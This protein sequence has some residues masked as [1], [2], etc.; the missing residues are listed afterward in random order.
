MT[1]QF[2]TEICSLEELG[3]RL[4]II[5]TYQRPYVWGDAQISKLIDD[6]WEA[7]KRNHTEYFIGTILTSITPNNQYELIDGQQRFTT[8]WLIAVAFK[9][10]KK[11]TLLINFLKV[12]NQLRIDFAIRS[13][14]ADYL[15]R[16]EEGKIIDHKTFEEQMVNDDYWLGIAQGVSS[17][18]G[19]LK[20]LAY[21]SAFS[22]S[23]FGDFIFK[24]IKFVKNTAPAN[25][26]LNQLFTTIN[27]SGLQLEQTD[28]LKSSLL[29]KI[30]K[31]KFFYSKVW[32]VCENMQNYFEKNVKEVFSNQNWNTIDPADF[33]TRLFDDLEKSLKEENISSQTSN[34]RYTLSKILNNSVEKDNYKDADL[35][36][37]YTI[38]NDKNKLVYCKSIVSFPQL[39][40]HAYRIYLANRAGESKRDFEQPFHQKNLLLIFKA[41]EKE[42]ETEVKMF[43][44]YLWETRFLLDK[45]VVK[46][47]QNDENDEEELLLTKASYY[48]KKEHGKETRYYTRT[49]RERNN[50]SMLQSVLYF[51]GNYNTQIWLSPYL[52]AMRT[53][54][55]KEVLT[56]LEE[57]DNVLSLNTRLAPE[58]HTRKA[59][60]FLMMTEK[61]K[62]V[63]TTQDRV[64]LLE[65]Y[66]NES[67]G[68]SFKH[69]WFQKL[70][71]IL[72]K[73]WTK[74]GESQ[75]DK[76]NRYRITSK[77]SVEHVFP[78]N[79]EF[80]KEIDKKSLDSFGNLG[81]LSV[82]QN[83]SY[84]HQDVEKKKVDFKNKT[85]YDS[86]KLYYIYNNDVED[87]GKEKIDAH[88]A[89]MIARIK[90]HYNKEH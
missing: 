80:G 30:S 53:A 57:I 73:N 12:D 71:Y 51:T 19:K 36:V 26:D 46:W 41:L 22:A 62:A 24:H 82:S 55:E 72:W 61:E 23:G 85:T 49:K 31:H 2:K 16:L 25:T 64:E 50:C 43:F 86:L 7:Y 33:Q 6:F 69:Y 75:N 47:L 74:N 52:N 38:A 65:E 34:N 44:R 17:I 90:S 56:I 3:N 37:D 58:T 1:A 67:N 15:Q 27:N 66:L 83:S 45:Y 60:S 4:F 70:E 77:N 68:T 9:L 5:P 20:N 14:I 29:K 81:L 13:Q 32:A 78:R 35:K 48:S 21:D 84:S 18:I 76:F 10:W 42:G 11:D 54:Q 63:D 8:L 39:L 87:W 88:R 79:E 40:L 28:I 59:L 89:D